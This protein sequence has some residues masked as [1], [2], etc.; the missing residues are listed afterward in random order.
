MSW[1]EQAAC[2]GA[3]PEGAFTLSHRA[4]RRFV[5]TYCDACPV[6][7]ACLDAAMVEEAGCRQWDRFGVRGGL[8]AAA[9]A[10]LARGTADQVL[11]PER[12]H[13]LIVA[14]MAAEDED[15]AASRAAA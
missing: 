3:D 8:T 14:I 4:R 7:D 9:R 10:D 11:T 2:R 12:L 15:R 1:M 5:A 6:R 13:P